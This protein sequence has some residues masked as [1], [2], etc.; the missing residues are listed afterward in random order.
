MSESAQLC[1]EIGWKWDRSAE[2][3]AG[4]VIDCKGSTAGAV[5][6]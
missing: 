1:T 5:K 2:V 3:P 4:S 6:G